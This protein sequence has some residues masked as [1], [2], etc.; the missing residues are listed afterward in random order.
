MLCRGQGGIG[1]AVKMLA[2]G[3]DAWT[4]GTRGGGDKQKELKYNVEFQ[5]T[6]PTYGT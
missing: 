4:G 3:D 5:A 2:G 1:T 6:G